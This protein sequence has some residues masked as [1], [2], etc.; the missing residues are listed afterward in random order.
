MTSSKV[1]IR[2]LIS[3]LTKLL[4]NNKLTHTK[5]IRMLD[6]THETLELDINTATPADVQSFVDAHYEAA[7]RATCVRILRHDLPFQGPALRTGD[8]G[9]LLLT[10]TLAENGVSKH[11]TLHTYWPPNYGT[12]R[13]GERCGIREPCND[14]DRRTVKR[15]SRN[16]KKRV[17]G[18]EGR[19]QRRAAKLVVEESAAND[20]G[21]CVDREGQAIVVNGE[22]GGGKGP[23]Q[24]EGR[25]AEDDGF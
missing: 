3:N 8:H 22:G 15:A 6:G 25:P 12:R 23:E 17:Q 14:A 2:K 10:K 16:E 19:A 13:D 24:Q 21:V 20:M 9:L 4:R 11:T 1:P 5:A 18:A 7:W